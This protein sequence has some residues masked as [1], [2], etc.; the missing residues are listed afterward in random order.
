MLLFFHDFPQ[1]QGISLSILLQTSVQISLYFTVSMICQCESKKNL[2]RSGVTVKI[3]YMDRGSVRSSFKSAYNRYYC[4][5][6]SSHHRTHL[7]LTVQSGSIDEKIA[8]FIKSWWWMW[9]VF[10]AVEVCSLQVQ[11]TSGKSQ[12]FKCQIPLQPEIWTLMVIFIKLL[13][14]QSYM[15]EPPEQKDSD[16]P[17]NQCCFSEPPM[18]K[19]TNIKAMFYILVNCL[20]I[21]LIWHTWP[22][23][24]FPRL[25]Q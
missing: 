18:D 24:Y 11:T 2:I 19:L 23:S 12:P 20:I 6:S 13:N 4:V 3:Q 16:Q 14:I 9:G 1:S 15:F 10:W 22:R 25:G 7:F 8:H 5:L 17:K 21:G